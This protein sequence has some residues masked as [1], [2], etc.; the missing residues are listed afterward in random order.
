MS[1]T[2]LRQQQRQH[3]DMEAE[4][5]EDMCSM[6]MTST[7][8]N[9]AE[10]GFDIDKLANQAFF[11]EDLPGFAHFDVVEHDQHGTNTINDSSSPNRYIYNE[12]ELQREQERRMRQQQNINHQSQN[13]QQVNNNYSQSTNNF[14]LNMANRQ[15]ESLSF[16]RDPSYTRTVSTAHQT[17]LLFSQENEDEEALSGEDE[18]NMPGGHNAAAVEREQ[19]DHDLHRDV[20]SSDDDLRRIAAKAA[21]E[22][23]RNIINKTTSPKSRASQS[24]EGEHGDS[25]KK[26][27]TNNSNTTHEQDHLQGTQQDTQILNDTLS[28]LGQLDNADRPKNDSCASEYQVR[29][30]PRS[31]K[32]GAL[33]N[34][35]VGGDVPNINT[36]QKKQLQRPGSAPCLPS[37]IRYL[38][39][40]PNNKKENHVA[41]ANGHLS[42]KT[43]ENLNLEPEDYHRALD[44]NSRVHD[45]QELLLKQNMKTSKKYHAFVEML[46]DRKRNE[47]S[48]F[49]RRCDL[50]Q[51]ETFFNLRDYSSSEGPNIDLADYNARFKRDKPGTLQMIFVFYARLYTVLKNIEEY[52]IRLG[53]NNYDSSKESTSFFLPYDMSKHSLT[54]REI[55]DFWLD[56]NLKKH[57][58][59][60]KCTQI[61]QAV[62]TRPTLDSQNRVGLTLEEFVKF[63]V[64]IAQEIYR[65]QI[66]KPH[67]RVQ[68]LVSFLNLHRWDSV[69][70][71]LR[72]CFRDHH[73]QKYDELT[74]FAVV[75]KRLWLLTKAAKTTPKFDD[76]KMFDKQNGIDV[77]RFGLHKYLWLNVEKEWVKFTE[78]N[79]YANGIN[80]PRFDYAN[81]KSF[82]C[83]VLPFLDCGIISI[84][85]TKHFKIKVKNLCNHKASFKMEPDY[86][87][88]PTFVSVT[89]QCPRGGV[90]Q[91]GFIEGVVKVAPDF[92]KEAVGSLVVWQ[93]SSAGEFREAR[94]PLYVKAVDMEMWHEGDPYPSKYHTQIGTEI[95]AT[96][97]KL[98]TNCLPA[99][100]PPAFHRADT[101]AV[102]MRREIKFSLNK[103]ICRNDDILPKDGA[104]P[105]KKVYS[106][107]K[108]T[109]LQQKP[110]NRASVTMGNLGVRTE[111]KMQTEMGTFLDNEPVNAQNFGGIRNSTRPSTA[112]GV[113]S[114]G[115]TAAA[116]PAGMRQ[117][118]LRT[119]QRPQSSAGMMTM[120]EQARFDNLNR[121]QAA[122]SVP[123]VVGPKRRFLGFS[124]EE[125]EEKH[126]TRE[127]IEKQR[128]NQKATGVI[129]GKRIK[130]CRPED[131][132]LF[133]TAFEL[134]TELRDSDEEPFA[135]EEKKPPSR[136][137][138]WSSVPLLRL[139]K[140]DALEKEQ[141]LKQRRHDSTISRNRLRNRQ[142]VQ[143]SKFYNSMDTAI[144]GE[145]QTL[146]TVNLAAGEMMNTTSNAGIKN[147]DPHQVDDK[148]FAWKKSIPTKEEQQVREILTAN[149]RPQKV[150]H[151]PEL[152]LSNSSLTSSSGEQQQQR[153]KQQ[154]GGNYKQGGDSSSV[155]Q[156]YPEQQVDDDNDE[157]ALAEQAAAQGT[158]IQRHVGQ[159]DHAMKLQN[160]KQKPPGTQPPKRL[161]LGE[162]SVATPDDEQSREEL[163]SQKFL[164]GPGAGPAG[165]VSSGQ[166]GGFGMNKKVVQFLRPEDSS[167]ISA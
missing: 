157:Q 11:E 118:P 73:L 113:G 86:H 19:Q 149:S 3:D 164:C 78:Q 15:Q 117:L 89:Y 39:Q 101:N 77:K 105:D 84:G 81:A 87:N 35:E 69:K 74:D 152:K 25:L 8:L 132:T 59:W 49:P 41:L 90:A 36:S 108:V 16:L 1:T 9:L 66:V 79:S 57:I 58:N 115:S 135:E 53:L 162:A 96:D 144:N 102:K 31:P 106:K 70:S 140:S 154:A 29:S 150:L 33:R 48:R 60:Y 124:Q 64:L 159:V 40:L 24:Y 38:V 61:Y 71:H 130:H 68:T 146:S 93:K 20:Y 116:S 100:I 27:S 98:R 145:Q 37:R 99:T 121:I 103:K 4:I 138:A 54:L 26:T 127:R 32:Q 34:D 134:D 133:G 18:E 143:N 129:S 155:H 148:N 104:K 142:I 30:P 46:K 166:L 95:P 94:I 151:Y 125:L 52:Q 43:K 6:T 158:K 111:F 109:K 122:T 83:S 45:L 5:F 137:N 141:Y 161:I 91:G 12:A 51:I 47:A 65:F 10:K 110:A 123:R 114:S 23:N 28:S 62:N 80:M 82:N 76:V 2:L 119:L 42:R 50:M 167:Y 136:M 120:N 67:K 85:E 17:T 63:L 107:Q 139:T 88:C 160:Q 147:N 72:N 56:F 163:F 165:G 55:K 112:G 14:S 13:N 75:A 44:H 126:N 131:P 97:D 128:Q 7:S 92:V 22:N 21:P 153:N 156:F